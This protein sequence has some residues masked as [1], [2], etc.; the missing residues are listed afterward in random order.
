MNI[1][2]CKEDETLF[3]LETNYE[4]ESFCSNWFKCYLSIGWELKDQDGNPVQTTNKG[5]CTDR[6]KC[7]N[8]EEFCLDRNECFKFYV[9]SDS[10]PYVIREGYNLYQEGA[11]VMSNPGYQP[12]DDQYFSCMTSTPS[13]SPTPPATDNIHTNPLYATLLAIFG[14]FLGCSCCV[15][16][17][18]RSGKQHEPKQQQ[19]PPTQQQQYPAEETS[20]E[21]E[22]RKQYQS[23]KILTGFLVN[24]VSSFISVAFSVGKKVNKNI[25]L[26]L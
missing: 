23:F 7:S 5:D 15:G 21:E 13:S 1:S 12:I 10:N 16:L 4:P 9:S 2:A 26:N 17:F 19:K 11:L 3:R 18:F 8:F 24:N 20:P 14:L 25:R 22:T 6:Q